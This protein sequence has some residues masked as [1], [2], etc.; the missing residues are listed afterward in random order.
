MILLSQILKFLL[1]V[2]YPYW[3]KIWT[4]GISYICIKLKEWRVLN[5]HEVMFDT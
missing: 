5:G 1:K 4:M 2:Y 3:I